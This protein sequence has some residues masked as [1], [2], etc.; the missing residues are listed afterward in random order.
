MIFP[1][2][3]YI[4]ERK[5]DKQTPN[6][7]KANALIKKAINRIAHIKKQS[8]GVE[9]AEFLFEDIYESIREAGQS[10]MAAK[11]YK[12]LSHEA[13]I[14]FVRDNYKIDADKINRFDR[15]RKIRN[16]LVYEADKVSVEDVKEALDFA[17][18]FV[19]ELSKL[20]K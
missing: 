9:D 1:F 7:E 13:V 16:K 8:L 5:V 18:S 19:K 10:L 15:C 17:T 3:Y 12:P 4:K 20:L 14:A 6:I 2:D 11:G